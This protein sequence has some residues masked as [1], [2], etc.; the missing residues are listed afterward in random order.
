[1]APPG[2]S[3][4]SPPA[5]PLVLPLAPPGLC[6]ALRDLALAAFR[7]EERLHDAAP[8]KV[9]NIESELVALQEAKQRM[10][11]AF[12]AWKPVIT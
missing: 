8:N 2:V 1:M 6:P 4:D 3:A 11:D 10:C 7:L 5:A 9:I 12:R